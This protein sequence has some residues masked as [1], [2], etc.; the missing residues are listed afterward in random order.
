MKDFHILALSGGG[1]RGLFTALALADME[2]AAGKPIGQCFD[3][4]CG[5]SIGGMIAMGLGVE[6]PVQEMADVMLD[7]GRNIFPGKGFKMFGG[8][9]IFSAKHSNRNLREVVE[10][11]FG[12][13]TMADSKR[14]LLIPVVNYSNGKPRIFKSLCGSHLVAGKKWKMADI[15]MAATAAPLYF[16]MWRM[17]D[18]SGSTVYIDG[19][20]YA[21]AP[22]LLG[23]H[24]LAFNLKKDI[25]RISLLSVGTMCADARIGKSSLNRGIWGWGKGGRLF[26]IAVSAQENLAN[27]MLK[28][29]LGKER[30][31]V[32]D[33]RPV[34]E[35]SECLGLDI[36]T[37]DAKN[38]LRSAA[39]NEMQDFM[40]PANRK[41]WLEHVPV[42]D[43]NQGEPQ[44]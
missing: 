11:V 25:N 31:Q 28:Q 6:K 38:I 20:L 34:G 14:P 13:K 12:D 41:K 42:S 26:D 1:F 16:P 4:I 27:F 39:Q 23:V 36:V 17:P 33:H 3:L 9:K 5:T 29:Q 24:E 2:E 19:G 8:L 37:D 22:G 32:I 44:Q 21:T 7:K 43:F 18:E 30:Y 10:S 15:A 40:T 35:Q